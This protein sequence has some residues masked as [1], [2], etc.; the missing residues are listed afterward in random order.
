MPGEWG[1]GGGGGR[2]RRRGTARGPRARARPR[3]VLTPP[4]HHFPTQVI[5]CAL[6]VA[7]ANN[8]RVDVC[9]GHTRVGL[10]AWHDGVR[11]PAVGA[12]PLAPGWYDTR[13]CQQGGHVSPAAHFD[14]KDGEE[15]KRYEGERG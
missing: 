3:D 5:G 15:Y 10:W 2:E 14:R 9:A 13:F 12:P 8:R 6:P 11:K 7:V 4:H 1:G